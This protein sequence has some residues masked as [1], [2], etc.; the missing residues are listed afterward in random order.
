MGR[1][2]KYLERR[3]TTAVRL[4]ESLHRQLQEVADERDTS[5]NHLITKAA[6]TYLTTLPALGPDLDRQATA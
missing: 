3:V 5:I 1:P 6:Q 4:P 2:K